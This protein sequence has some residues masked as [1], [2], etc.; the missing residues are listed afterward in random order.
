MNLGNNKKEVITENI[1]LDE[2]DIAILQLLE[3]DAK[4]TIRD[5][6]ARLNLS[7]TP[8]YERIRKM[9][10]A[11]VIRQYAAIIDPS[12]I[13]KAL[14]VL[15]YISLKEHGKKAGGKFIKEII[16]FPEVMECLNISGEFDFMLKVQVKDMYAYH[17]FN[18]NKLGELDNIRHM[19]SVF[20]M[21]VIK[22]THRVVY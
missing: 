22:A 16:S 2:K 3:E 13:D 7:A 21:S 9:E 5:L 1:A 19:E 6:A 18:V 12:K 8:V 4:M 20:V 14:T 15:C 10:Q 17:E 11:G